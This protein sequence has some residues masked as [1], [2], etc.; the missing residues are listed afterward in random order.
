MSSFSYIC[1]GG[2]ISILIFAPGFFFSYRSM[3]PRKPFSS[4]LLAQVMKLSDP[5]D[6]E[7]PPQ[8]PRSTSPAPAPMPVVRKSRR[9]IPRPVDRQRSVIPL[10]FLPW[11]FPV[12]KTNVNL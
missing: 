6:S 4:A 2:T 8:P 5:E 10:P 1:S 9:V 7:P 12:A 3:I 11:P